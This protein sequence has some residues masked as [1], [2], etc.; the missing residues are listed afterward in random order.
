MPLRQELAQGLSFNL[1][2]A[3]TNVAVV[4]TPPSYVGWPA[5]GRFMLKCESEL[6]EVTSAVTHPWPIAR[7]QEGTTG[8][9]HVL[10]A[11]VTSPL[12]AGALGRLVGVSQAGALQSTSRDLNVVG[13][14]VT[15]V[16]G[17]AT[18]TIDTRGALWQVL[19]D[20]ASIPWNLALGSGG[21]TLGGNRALANPTNIVPGRFA[22]KVVQDGTGTRLLTW[23]AAYLHPGGTAPTLSVA[24][25]AVDLFEFVSD[26]T[27]LYR[28]ASALALA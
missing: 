22:L 1:A 2:S 4:L 6:I 27:N 23:G 7:G 20:G 11:L 3:L 14:V 28:V 8:A 24:A 16:A 19:V 9:S 26:G 15:D 10:G 12:T 25:G 21:V 5:T 17:V 18:V 13:A